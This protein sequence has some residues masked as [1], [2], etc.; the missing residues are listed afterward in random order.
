MAGHA[1][2]AFWFS[3]ASGQFVTSTYYY[4]QYPDWVANWNAE[5]HPDRYAGTSW[6]LLH[7]RESYLF[8]D[9]DDR[10]DLPSR[11]LYLLQH[12]GKA[13]PF[14]SKKRNEDPGGPLRFRQR[15]E[16]G[17]RRYPFDPLAQIEDVTRGRRGAE[18]I[19][20]RL[21]VHAVQHSALQQSHL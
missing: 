19:L 2:K 6:K 16:P 12:I 9:A 3:K 7:A 11:W 10:N 18:S 14:E 17:D 15:G 20:T 4:E 5:R 8:G 1:G 21:G 13:W